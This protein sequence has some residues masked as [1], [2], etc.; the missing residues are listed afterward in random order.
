MLRNV[1]LAVLG[2][3]IVT[4]GEHRLWA[5]TVPFGA[6]D[7]DSLSTTG[8]SFQFVGTLT[9]NYTLELTAS[10]DPCLQM[11]PS[12]NSAV[13]CVN[14]AGVVIV[15]SVT[16]AVGSA[17]AFTDTFGGTTGTWDYGSLLMEIG[18]TTI[19]VFPADAANGLGSGSPPSTLTLPSATLS[20]L[21]FTGLDLVDPTITFL[22]ADNLYPDNSGTFTV[23]GQFEL[24]QVPEP[25][26]VAVV[27][28]LLCALAGVTRRF[29]VR[30]P[31]TRVK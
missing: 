21:G 19:Q 13:Y 8:A 22:L 2:I 14:A 25:T 15:P 9:D 7:V 28:I 23:S 27:G 4:T 3:G 30:L 26:N 20:S 29:G 24:S 18:N 6:I 10:G 31:Q 17:A 5:D 16:G 11:T 12:N 1:I